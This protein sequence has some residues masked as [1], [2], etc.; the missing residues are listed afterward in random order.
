MKNCPSADCAYCTI[1]AP[2]GDTVVEPTPALVI[3]NVCKPCVPT[4][5]PAIC[6]VGM[7]AISQRTIL[8]WTKRLNLTTLIFHHGGDHNIRMD[9]E[10]YDSSMQL[11]IFETGGQSYKGITRRMN[12]EIYAALQSGFLTYCICRQICCCLIS[13]A[14][15]LTCLTTIWFFLNL[16][17]C[18]CRTVCQFVQY[19]SGRKCHKC[20]VTWTIMFTS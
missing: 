10:H 2:A 18:D 7:T 5:E 14:V 15:I 6:I 1:V 19:F 12:N 4:S 17:N 13:L 11:H 8:L 3:V 16:C 20:I 9:V